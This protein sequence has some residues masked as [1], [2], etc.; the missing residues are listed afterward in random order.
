MLDPSETRPPAKFLEAFGWLAIRWSG[1]ELMIEI[2]CAYI[3][4]NKIVVDNRGAPPRPF[5]SR[6]KFV[7]KG[8]RHPAFAHIRYDF[9]RALQTAESLADERN[10]L[11]HGAFTRWT[12]SDDPIQTVVRSYDFGYIASEDKAV[13]IAELD[14][15]ATRIGTA[16]FV[17]FNLIDRFKAILRAIDGEEDL[18]R[19]MIGGE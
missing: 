5:R 6:I 18:G 17:H 4:Q 2:S 12:G 10:D 7:R 1:L 15:L 13:S 19:R 3:F 11:M 16:F 8:L 14:D 9:E